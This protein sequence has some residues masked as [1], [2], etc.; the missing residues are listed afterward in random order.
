MVDDGN[1]E[2]KNQDRSKKF[3]CDQCEYSACRLNHL[4]KHK[5]IKYA[6]IRY[7]CDQCEYYA[8]RADK[9]KQHK[10]IKHEG[11]RYP[12][13]QNFPLKFVQTA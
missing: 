1:S 6:G 4:K 5:E 8:T 12:V 9:L 11:I 7:P 2:A 10:D 13:E 3:P